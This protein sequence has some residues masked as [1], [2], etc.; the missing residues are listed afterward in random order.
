[1]KLNLGCG[2][3]PI[4]GFVN[5]DKKDGGWNFEMGLP[6]YPEHTVQGITISHALMYVEEEFWPFVFSECYR[7]L[8]PGSVL[9][10]TEDVTDD[11]RSI[12][13]PN[14]NPGDPDLKT[15]T[16]SRM[17]FA[18]MKSAGFRPF[19]VDPS[20]TMSGDLRMIQRLH[21]DPPHVFHMEGVK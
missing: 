9:R 20:Y 2:W 14:G 21:G 17:V 10:V 3:S 7:V 12:R 16:S 18:A 15:L 8:V 11:P 6:I 19:W 1:M 4:E 13:Y 5:L